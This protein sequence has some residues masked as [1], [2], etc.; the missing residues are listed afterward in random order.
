MVTLPELPLCVLHII[1]SFLEIKPAFL[2]SGVCRV[3]HKA[4]GMYFMDEYVKYNWSIPA[5]GTV[6]VDYFVMM[7]RK[8]R[9]VEVESKGN[10]PVPVVERIQ[11]VKIVTVGYRFVAMGTYKHELLVVDEVTI[12]H[13]V[14]FS[15]SIASI[16]AGI[17]MIAVLLQTRQLHLLTLSADLQIQ[18]HLP[19]STPTLLTC[20]SMSTLLFT[21]LSN[22][23]YQLTNGTT[24]EMEF[25]PPVHSSVKEIASKG[26]QIII[27]FDN[28]QLYTTK[29]ASNLAKMDLFFKKK[30]VSLVATGLYHSL[31]LQRNDVPGI[32]QWTK[33]E[34]VSWMYANKYADA[35]QILAK[36]AISGLE[37]SS[38]S[39]SQVQQTFQIT[40]KPRLNRLI[41]LIEAVKTRSIG[42]KFTLYG[43]GR[44]FN[45]Q[46]GKLT[47]NFFSSPI[48]ID[49]PQLNLRENVEFLMCLKT[50]SVVFTTEKR[51]FYMG[52]MKEKH[53]IVDLEPS[54]WTELTLILLDNSP[55]LS[56]ESIFPG[57]NSEFYYLTTKKVTEN[58]DFS[59]KK[60]ANEVIKQMKWDPEV[61]I[62]EW[63]I[64]FNT[65]L[66]EVVTELPAR[67]FYAQAIPAREIVYFK[68]FGRVIWRRN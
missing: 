14:P 21:D 18:A 33:E 7:S 4:A 10:Q 47:P 40:E 46:L 25:T 15:A 55:K 11:G 3:F 66:S 48:K 8:L 34:V 52:G 5:N 65:D 54:I 68:R 2:C 62:A 19:V 36:T 28:G 6:I 58:A 43:W 56:I 35:A 61:N 64:G 60:G 41:S 30:P 42:E 13:K 38:F 12:H 9:R 53:Q 32:Q 16:C 37:I 20:I 17:D 39:D 59:R 44:N 45:C 57:F 27:L 63:V 1:L 23:V 26:R 29:T 24:T 49:L 22:R 51:V 50:V 31:A 67:E